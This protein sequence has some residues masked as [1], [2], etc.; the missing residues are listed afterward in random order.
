MSPSSGKPAEKTGSDGFR[1]SPQISEELSSKLRRR[2]YMS[3]GDHDRHCFVNTKDVPVSYAERPTREADSMDRPPEPK[4]LA[5]EP[6]LAERGAGGDGQ[7]GASRLPRAGESLQ[8]AELDEVSRASGTSEASAEAAADNPV[9]ERPP[10]I[11]TE[12]Y[13]LE[14]LDERAGVNSPALGATGPCIDAALAAPGRSSLLVHAA[15]VFLLV[16]LVATLA[17]CTGVCQQLSIPGPPVHLPELHGARSTSDSSAPV[18]ADAAPL[19][20]GGVQ[21]T[22]DTGAPPAVEGDAGNPECWSDGFTFEM[23]CSLLHGAG[24][25]AA[26]WDS[27][28]NYQRCCT[29]RGTH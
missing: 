23:C 8:A 11:H 17:F 22:G 15:C 24:G 26:C 16:A 18:Q 2:R 13:C 27:F 9:V 12:F 21:G 7:R 5:Q 4:C 1:H 6:E 28:Y 19:A 14:A 29:P 10:P 20:A 25:N 3:E